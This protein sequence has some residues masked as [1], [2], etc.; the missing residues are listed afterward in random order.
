MGF[1]ADMSCSVDSNLHS[2]TWLTGRGLACLQGLAYPL[3][4]SPDLT[5]FL[6]IIGQPYCT[7]QSA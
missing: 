6:E 1:E 5:N 2:M 4:G 3:Q 7:L